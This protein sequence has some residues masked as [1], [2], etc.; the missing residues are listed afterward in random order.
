MNVR[1]VTCTICVLAGTFA[2]LGAITGSF[3][4]LCSAVSMSISAWS[5]FTTAETHAILDDAGF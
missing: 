3:V 4:T 2:M 1:V 5:L